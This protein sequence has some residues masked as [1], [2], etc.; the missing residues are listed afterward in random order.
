MAIGH[1]VVVADMVTSAVHLVL[2]AIQV[3]IHRPATTVVIS[4]QTDRHIVHTPATRHRTH[5]IGHVMRTI[6]GM[7][8]TVPTRV[9]GIIRRH[10]TTAVMN[11]RINMRITALIPVLRHQI[12]VH[13]Y[14][15]RDTNTTVQPAHAMRA[16]DTKAGNT[17][18]TP[19]M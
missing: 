11:V 10:M 13:G 12:H 4:V 6:I 3:G 2:H 1:T 15:M 8:L 16:A 7:A 19:K 5:V 14:V 17:A 18:V 9:L